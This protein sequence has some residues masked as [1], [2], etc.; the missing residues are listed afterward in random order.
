VAVADLLE[1]EGRAL[2]RSTARLGGSLVLFA[3]AGLLAAV[4]LCL[5]LWGLYQYLAVSLGGTAA[6]LLTGVTT[7][8]IAGGLL[9]I[10]QRMSR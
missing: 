8:V 4:G 10:G 6:A 2:R 1:A 7:V 9:W 3:L 5:C